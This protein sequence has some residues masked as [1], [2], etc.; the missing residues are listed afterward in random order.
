MGRAGAANSPVAH[1]SQPGR[2]AV[3]F[4]D[5]ARIRS[6]SRYLEELCNAKEAGAS[7][8]LHGPYAH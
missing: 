6:L 5:A 1:F 8:A 4:S 7:F 2:P 3:R